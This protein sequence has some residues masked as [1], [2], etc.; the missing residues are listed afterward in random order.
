MKNVEINR[1][2]NARGSAMIKTFIEIQKNKQFQYKSGIILKIDDI[3]LAHQSF[4]ELVRQINETNKF[5]CQ[6]SK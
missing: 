1:V 2:L 4:H 5:Y 6:N 3:N